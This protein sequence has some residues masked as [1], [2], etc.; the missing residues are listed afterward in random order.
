MGIMTS[1]VIFSL[2]YRSL[3]P[4]NPE[5]AAKVCEVYCGDRG[6]DDDDVGEECELGWR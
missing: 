1:Q 3:L 2:Y 4:P 5:G 6:Y